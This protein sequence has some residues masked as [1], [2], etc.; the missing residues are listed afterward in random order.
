[1]L[2]ARRTMRHLFVM[3][4]FLCLAGAAVSQD[5][6]DMPPDQIYSRSKGS[7]VTILTFDV[8]KA[9]LEQGSGFVIAQ[10]RIITNYHVMA[11]SASASIVFD[12]GTTLPVSTLAAGSVQLDIAILPVNTG[13]RAPLPLGDELEVKV[14]QSVYAIGAPQG[15]SASLSNGLVSAFR[16]DGGQ[17]LIQTTANISPGS[18]GGPLFDK[19][20]RVI[21]ITTSK[22]KDGSFSF[23]IGAGDIRHLLKV[24][25]SAPQK[26]ADLQ[27]GDD[28]PSATDAGL[29]ATQA[30][31]DQKKYT[32]AAISFKRLPDSVRATYKGELLLC[33]VEVELPEHH[34]DACDSASH[35]RPSE[36]TPYGL[37]A[38]AALASQNLELSETNALKAVQLSNDSGD[39][40]L[41]GFIYYLQERYSL[42]SKE[43]SESSNSVFALTLLEGSA[44]RTG[45]T[46]TFN[47]LNERINS[48]KGVANGWQLYND[49][50]SAQQELKWDVALDDF[51]KCDADSD[52]VDPICALSV[53]NVEMMQGSRAEAKM[54][55][56]AALKR[57]YRSSSVMSDAI[58][59]D[60]VIGD[61]AAAKDLHAKLEA[62]TSPPTDSTDCL[63]YYGIDQPSLA[64]DHCVAVVNADDKSDLAWSNAGYVA[65]DL[66][67]YQTALMDFAKSQKIYTADNTKHTITQELDHMWGLL[68]A[69][70]MTGDK[71]DA[72]DLYRKLKKT[73][74]DFSSVAKLQQ[75]PLVWSKQT[76]VLLA[77][78]MGD[79]K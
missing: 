23:A 20:G 10:N 69:C 8:N 76:Q 13:G 55:I 28:T 57:F 62:K 51:R 41:L 68:L 30:L 31:Y 58:F 53:A 24:P 11:G 66:G 9:P 7:V 12:D 72:K 45:D 3:M 5:K 73:Y 64:N 75:L 19:N 59:I 79:F 63:Y 47:R 50:A 39:K 4:L 26:L 6:G 15:L 61:K 67:Q 36:S 42:V 40:Q 71:K 35:L 29:A 54:H 34:D 38:Y 32:E 70:Y 46:D 21:G 37:K 65:L 25:P 77:N 1:M 60:L 49:G 33:R 43:I 17:F 52:F 44:L 16:E 56:D 48:I 18:S 14:G 22:L 27:G 2:I 74:P 78:V